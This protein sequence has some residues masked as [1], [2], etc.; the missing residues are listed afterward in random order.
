MDISMDFLAPLHIHA[1]QSGVGTGCRWLEGRGE[2]IASYSPV[3]GRLIAHFRAADRQEYEE[4]VAK[5]RQAFEAWRQV[6]PPVRGEFVRRWVKSSGSISLCLAGW[7]RM[8]WAKAC[9]KAGARCRR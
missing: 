2:E 8:K 6:P 9:K 4:V 1:R 5:A 3:D 7:S